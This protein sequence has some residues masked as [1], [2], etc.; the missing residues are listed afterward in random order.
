MMKSHM[1][2][3][4]CLIGDANSRLFPAVVADGKS[5]FFSAEN[6]FI[7]G[8][9]DE[10]ASRARERRSGCHLDPAASL[11]TPAIR[12]APVRLR[13][14]QVVAGLPQKFVNWAA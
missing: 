6:G 8:E 5:G 2:K 4:H 14:F 12:W 7:A 3:P 9:G 10:A 13:R 11:S 1:V